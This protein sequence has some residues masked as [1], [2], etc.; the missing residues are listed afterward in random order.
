MRRPFR[1]CCRTRDSPV[2]ADA[3]AHAEHST[4]TSGTRE[5][6]TAPTPRADRTRELATPGGDASTECPQLSSADFGARVGPWERSSSKTQSRGRARPRAD[7]RFV[8]ETGVGEPLADGGPAHRQH[9]SCAVARVG[10]RAPVRA[11]A[12]LARRTRR[13]GLGVPRRT[14]A[15]ARESG[16]QHGTKSAPVSGAE[17][18]TVAAAWPWP[19]S[20][21]SP[22]IR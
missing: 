3:G 13:S 20:A 14:L 6:R 18:C 8:A 16:C 10:K 7:S 2:A 1:T 11:F 21:R 5:P 4:T 22:A 12:V 17:K 19:W 15:D 9:A